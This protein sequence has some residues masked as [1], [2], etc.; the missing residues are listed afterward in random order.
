MRIALLSIWLFSWSGSSLAW[1]GK[2]VAI[3]DGDTISALQRGR[4]IK[5][6][7]NAIDAPELHQPFG[8]QSRRSLSGLCYGRFASIESEARDKYG[9][10][11]AHVRCGGVDV[12]AEQIR[13]GMA[14]HYAKYSDSAEL[15]NLEIEARERRRG[16]W[17]SGK[18]EPP[19]DYRHKDDPKTQKSAKLSR[20][21]PEFRRCGTKRH[22]GQMETC[23]EAIYYLRRCGV[24]GLDGNGDGVPCESL[25]RP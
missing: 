22:C 19:W 18:P 6:R 16:L 5:V 3:H 7:L 21:L 23:G 10:V 11:V 25:C 8:Q 2:V 9:R 4:A 12:N 20:H 1:T 14:W 13:R 24:D 15:R 17:S